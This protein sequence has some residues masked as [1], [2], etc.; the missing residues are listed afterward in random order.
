MSQPAG[1]NRLPMSDLSVQLLP[2]ILVFL[3]DVAREGG[4]LRAA[5][6]TLANFSV[7]RLNCRRLQGLYRGSEN[8]RHINLC[9]SKGQLHK[10]T[11]NYVR[12]FS[13]GQVLLKLWFTFVKC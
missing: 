5:A 2:I 4:K 3:F 9:L 7:P 1:K 8:P 6:Q 10:C 12:I 13:L 11:H